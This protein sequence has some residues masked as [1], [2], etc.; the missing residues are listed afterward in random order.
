MLDIL[1][2]ATGIAGALLLALNIGYRQLAY[3]LFTFSSLAWLSI[4]ITIDN[5]PLLLMN[6]IFSAINIIGITRA[7]KDN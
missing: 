2:S 1:A 4:A 5:K 6:L 7:R 3:L